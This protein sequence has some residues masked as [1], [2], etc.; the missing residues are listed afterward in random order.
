M[1]KSGHHPLTYRP[2]SD[3]SRPPHPLTYMLISYHHPDHLIY[4]LT[5]TLHFNIYSMHECLELLPPISSTHRLHH[6]DHLIH[7]LICT[8][9]P[10]IYS[11]QVCFEYPP[12]T[13]PC[14]PPHTHEHIHATVYSKPH[15]SLT[16]IY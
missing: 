16:H 6:P 10:N 8:L 7:R 3:S 9:V 13:F 1:S 5:C 14:P 2:N 4:Q 12:P 15:H 11:M